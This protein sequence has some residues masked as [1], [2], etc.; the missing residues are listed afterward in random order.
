[1]I[2]NVIP[3]LA[4]VVAAGITFARLYRSQRDDGCPA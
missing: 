3:L 1:M 2:R 4:A